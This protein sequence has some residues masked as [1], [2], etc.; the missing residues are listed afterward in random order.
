MR[1][2]YLI[3]YAASA[4]L[5]AGCATG[6]GETLKI[7][8]R[9]VSAVQYMPNELTSMLRDLGYQWISIKDPETDLEVKTLQRFGE[10][11]MRFELVET[12]QVRI[13]VRIRVHD[14]FT[15]LHFYEPG[16]QTLS[17]SSTDLLEILRKRA[18]LEFGQANVR[19]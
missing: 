10:Y 8:I 18:V 17:P 3:V 1:V 7:D 4:L 5:L 11:R 16:S 14:G 6:G 2:L 9:K 12:G 13:D 15:R 19:F